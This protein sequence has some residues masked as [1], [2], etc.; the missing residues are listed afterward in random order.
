[1]LKRQAVPTRPLRGSALATREAIVDAAA[2]LFN[3]VGFDGT[4]SNAIA[5][6]AGYSPG[7]FYRHF[8]DKRDVF[9]AAYAR[10]LRAEWT[11]LEERLDALPPQPLELA[12][13]L[14][15]GLL[16]HHKSWRIFR[17]SLRALLGTDPE[18]RRALKSARKRQL[19]LIGRLRL[20]TGGKRSPDEDLLFLLTLERA[21]D[22]LVDGEL[23]EAGATR[24]KFLKLLLERTREQLD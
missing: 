16:A 3:E 10:H 19:E 2:G 1:M 13:G 8:E 24:G 9:L 21:C 17:G 22:A 11:A 6:A 5:R 14:V 15:D 18:V 23:D 4:D 12:S 20:R 7:T